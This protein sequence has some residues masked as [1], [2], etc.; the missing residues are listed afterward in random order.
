M[1]TWS[2][3]WDEKALAAPTQ[4][5]NQENLQDGE[6]LRVNGFNHDPNSLISVESFEEYISATA[7]LVCRD[8]TKYLYE[9]G[10]G[11]AGSS[12]KNLQAK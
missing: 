4:I 12:Q 11:T 6:L 1:K 9:F 2:Q 8:S 5:I 3:V 10:C 7:D